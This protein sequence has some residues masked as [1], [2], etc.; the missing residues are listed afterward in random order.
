MNCPKCKSENVNVT[1]EQTS[2]KT[3][4]R[5]MGCLWAM[6][7][8][9]LIMCTFGVWLLIGKRK[10]TG[11]IKFKNKTIALCQNCGYKWGI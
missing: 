11:D 10:E 4:I 7:R 1:L 9:M 2:A 8:W 3:K 6:G 5:R